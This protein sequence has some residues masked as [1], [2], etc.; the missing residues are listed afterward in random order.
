MC[1]YWREE[2]NFT[3]HS[4]SQNHICG[5]IKSDGNGTWRFVGIY[6]WPE[7]ENK[8]KT[9]N[10]IKQLCEESDIPLIF[11]GD[12]NE[13]LSYE[14]KEGGADILRQEMKQFRA[15]IDECGLR[16]LGFEGQWYTWERGN[17]PNTRVHERLDQ[18]LQQKIMQNLCD[19]SQRRKFTWH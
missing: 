12:F 11:G 14:E 2:I 8:H 17:S 6:G 1:L 13:I 15:A 10:L 4:L 19:L 16:D 7:S 18:S 3:L 5:D 9:W